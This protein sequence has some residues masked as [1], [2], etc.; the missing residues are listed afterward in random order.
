MPPWAFA[1]ASLGYRMTRQVAGEFVYRLVLVVP[2]RETAALW[3]ALG[4]LLGALEASEA[5]PPQSGARAWLLPARQKTRFRPGRFL[6]VGKYGWCVQLD[7]G[8]LKECGPR[9]SVFIVEREPTLEKVRFAQQLVAFA[10]GI[11]VD[12]RA[13]QCLTAEEAVVVAGS[14]KQLG[15]LLER[16]EIQGLRLEDL[17]LWETGAGRTFRLTRMVGDASEITDKARLLVVD[18]CR[19]FG[20][21]EDDALLES[22][23]PA[24]VLMTEDEWYAAQQIDPNRI[25][26]TFENWGGSRSE[27]PSELP[28]PGLGGLIFKKAAS[29]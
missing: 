12:F 2:R 10:R 9:D 25:R 15:D 29:R 11:G 1:L 17:L 26:Q 3:V 19:D 16:L 7:K 4:G 20:I 18:G 23:H 24:I 21:L 28:Q 27:W 6:E 22:S 8:G 13:D 5:P 14:K